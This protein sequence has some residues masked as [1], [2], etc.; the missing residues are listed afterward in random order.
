VIYSRKKRPWLPTEKKKHTK[1]DIAAGRHG[2]RKDKRDD[3][4]KTAMEERQWVNRDGG[5]IVSAKSFIS[6]KG[7]SHRKED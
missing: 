4:D 1:H 7:F 6:S 5:N 2:E 3:E